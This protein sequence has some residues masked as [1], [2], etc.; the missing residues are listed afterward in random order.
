MATDSEP[1]SFHILS[2]KKKPS[3]GNDNA[4]SDEGDNENVDGQD[5]DENVQ[6][7]KNNAL[8]VEEKDKGEDLANVDAYDK[9]E[10]QLDSA[11]PNMSRFFKDSID[12]ELSASEVVANTLVDLSIVIR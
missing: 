5:E 2:T 7:N 8:V 12:D 9:D 4:H 1:S 11:N 3:K 10:T 6:V